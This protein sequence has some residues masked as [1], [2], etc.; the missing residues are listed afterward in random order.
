MGFITL[1]TTL[2]NNISS[3]IITS[4]V[5]HRFD[6]CEIDTDIDIFHIIKY[7]HQRDICIRLDVH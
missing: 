2:H 3:I 6:L 1:H 5:S 7:I 4:L